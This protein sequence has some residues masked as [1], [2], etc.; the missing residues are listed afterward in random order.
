MEHPIFTKIENAKKPDFGAILSK[1]FELFKKVWEQALYH[2][3]ITLAV[4]LPVILLI[5]IPYILFIFQMGGFDSY[6]YYDDYGF[7]REPNLAPYIPFLIVYVIVVLVI[8]FL[9][10][11]FVLGITAHFVKVLKKVDTGSAED[12]GGYFS[13]IK[14]N[15]MKL[16]LLSLASFGIALLATLACY[17]PIFYVMV[18]LQLLV[19]FYAFHPE[20]S[21]SDLVKASFKLGHK[22]WLTIFGLIIISSLIAQLGILLCIVG[23]FFTAYFVHIPMYYVYKDALG[24][25]DV[26]EENTTQVTS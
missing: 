4:M 23:V 21:V 20:M 19:V 13:L 7:Y 10:Q 8:I 11:A 1:S 17:L 3:L 22:F 18:P 6:G 12:V 14:G 25:D 2:V 26:P 5:Y 9:A 24:F 16:I 15:Y